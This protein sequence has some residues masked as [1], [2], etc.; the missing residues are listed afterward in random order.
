MRAAC[1]GR[2]SA[3]GFGI[4]SLIDRERGV[5]VHTVHLPMRDVR[6]RDLMAERLGVPVV[7]DNDAN[8]ALLAEHRFGAARGARHAVMLTLGTGIG[9]GVVVDGELCARPPAP[10]REL[11]HMTVDE[12]GPPCPGNCPNHGCLEALASGHG[13]GPRGAAR[14]AAT[15][16]TRGSAARWPPGARSPARSRPSWPTTATAPRATWSR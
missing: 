3:V 7:I 14:R 10:A 6:F 1:D 12:D 16:P 13:A 9:G 4:P 8:V 15:P 2:C 11:G 5:A